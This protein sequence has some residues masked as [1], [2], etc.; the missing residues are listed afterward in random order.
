MILMCGILVVIP[1]IFFVFVV[2]FFK[3]QY[4]IC[5]L[6]FF[7]IICF[8]IHQKLFV[9]KTIH[10]Q[11]EQKLHLAI[12]LKIEEVSFQFRI[13]IDQFLTSEKLIP[14]AQRAYWWLNFWRL[15][16]WVTLKD[17]HHDQQDQ[18][19]TSNVEGKC[20]RS[21]RNTWTSDEALSHLSGYV[22]K[23]N[24]SY[25]G[26]EISQLIHERLLHYVKV[27]VWWAVSAQR[28]IGL[29]VFHYHWRAQYAKC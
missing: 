6:R 7:I 4:F 10:L 22:N 1:F 27:T 5:G 24:W 28:I 29:F 25:W 12:T 9:L 16:L 23:Q 15:G 17:K 2:L 14:S 21:S 11:N 18:L 3:S 26:T 20:S 8:R 13:N 19:K